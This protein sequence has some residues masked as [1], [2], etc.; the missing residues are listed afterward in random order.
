M[1]AAKAPAADHPVLQLPAGDQKGDLHHLRSNIGRVNRIILQLD[2]Q[3]IFLYIALVAIT[4]N[5]VAY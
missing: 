3:I 4:H 5:P 1:T 2:A